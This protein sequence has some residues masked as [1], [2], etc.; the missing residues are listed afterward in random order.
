M[1]LQLADRALALKTS[2]SI[3]AKK[4]V[5]EL[6]AAGHKIIDF[7][8][9]AFV[10]AV[11]ATGCDITAVGDEHCLLGDADLPDVQ[12]DSVQPLLQEISERFGKRDHLRMEIVA[13]L[14]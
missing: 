14:H 13:F 5:S 7:T 6:H 10:E 11:A 4:M 3:A 12:G 9:P 1:S 2:A 8:I